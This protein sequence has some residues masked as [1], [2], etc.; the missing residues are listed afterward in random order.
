MIVVIPCGGKKRDGSH[1]ARDLYT[2][3]YFKAAYRYATS[4]VPESQVFILSAKYGLVQPGQRL[5][6][7]ELTLGQPGAVTP[8]YLRDQARLFAIDNEKDVLVVGGVRYVDLARKVWP[9]CRAPFGRDGGLLQQ[10]TI[11]YQLEA[12]KRWHG[13]VPA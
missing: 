11:G 8:T 7:Y 13:R 4:V 1:L 10:A 6:S 5:D 2:G 9:W 3:P 12:M